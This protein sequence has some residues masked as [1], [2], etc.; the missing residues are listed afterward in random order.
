M[1][2]VICPLPS[3][4]SV[5]APA[6]AGNADSGISPATAASTPVAT[7]AAVAGVA[8]VSSDGAATS[9]AAPGLLN[10]TAAVDA[11]FA[12][13]SADTPVTDPSATLDLVIAGG[14]TLS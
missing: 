9:S 6:A 11:V 4:V 14:G 1:P 2:S 3:L 12:T 13:F 10:N 8:P 5:T 7:T